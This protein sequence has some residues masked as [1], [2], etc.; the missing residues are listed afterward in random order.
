MNEKDPACTAVTAVSTVESSF[1]ST[2][3]ASPM[4]NENTTLK[5][6]SEMMR[7]GLCR[8]KNRAGFLCK[9]RA[10]IDGM[11]IMHYRKSFEE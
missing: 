1:T 2:T 11:C 4:S 7:E 10:V 6:L 8:Q 9:Q 3:L 5:V